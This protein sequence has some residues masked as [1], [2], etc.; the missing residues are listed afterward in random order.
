MPL[1]SCGIN[2]HLTPIGLRERLSVDNVEIPQVLHELCQQKAVN[3]AV[4]INTCHRTEFYWVGE[5]P[6]SIHQW[7]YNKSAHQNGID[8]HFYTH[9]DLA[10][11]R[12]LLRVS[13]GLDSMSIGEPQILGQIKQAYKVAC[14]V[15]TVGQQLKRLFP[16][17]FSSAKQIRQ[18]SQIGAHPISM[19][20]AAIQIAKRIFSHFSK[21]T[22]LLVGAGE[23][24]Q[25][26][27]THLRGQG[28][29]Q[30]IVA[31]RTLEKA[32]QLTKLCQGKAIRIADIPIYLPQADI[33]ITA[34]SSQ[35]PIIG[36][37]MMERILKVQKRRPILM[38]DLAVPRNI[39]PEISQLQDIYLYNVD[40]LQT[41]LTANLKNRRE[42]A[43]Q[44]EILIEL[45]A[46]HYMNQ[47]EVLNIGEIIQEFRKPA[48]LH[49]DLLLQKSLDD[50]KQG[51]PAEDII[52]QLAFQLTNKILHQPTQKL[53][54]AAYN[55]Q[56]ELLFVAKKLLT[57]LE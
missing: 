41:I 8:Q 9:Q 13:S 26:I 50:L 40:D 53:R 23:M 5:D 51:K 38:L 15:G 55:Q 19:A 42:A 1:F 44:A 46:E 18:Q 20:Y 16:A 48:I 52:T 25:L 56:K 22:V 12:H 17:A 6:V 47:L 3:E 45:Q 7:F 4:L 10:A 43:K 37:G 34:T 14:D 36:K 32:E 57:N 28:I 29:T 49:R 54:E 27:L 30:L 35:L 33:I 21:C 11:V 2:H 39:E 31:N 24:M